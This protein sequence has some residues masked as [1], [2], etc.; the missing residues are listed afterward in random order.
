MPTTRA[1]TRPG[2]VASTLSTSA[3][4][5]SP[6]EPRCV[7]LPVGV[8]AG[9]FNCG[10]DRALN[11]AIHTIALT[12]ILKVAVTT[13]PRLADSQRRSGIVERARGFVGRSLLKRLPGIPASKL[14][15]R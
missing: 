15:D 10:G 11:C 8:V 14:G 12:R 7:R 6:S 2:Y 9:Q 5:G 3:S 13:L 4:S 1:R